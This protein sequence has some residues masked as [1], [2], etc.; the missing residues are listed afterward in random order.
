MTIPEFTF[1]DE[2]S[3]LLA[4]VEV[5][6][7]LAINAEDECRTA[8]GRLSTLHVLLEEQVGKLRSLV[9]AQTDVATGG[10]R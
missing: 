6:L 5:V 4:R 2:M 1:L 9:D 8:S 10:A 3:V 7:E